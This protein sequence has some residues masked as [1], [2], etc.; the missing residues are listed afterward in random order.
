MSHY[1]FIVNPTSGRGNGRRRLPQ[2]EQCLNE[3][4]V[5]YELVLTERPLHATEIAYRAAQD[6][7]DVVVAVGGDGT[8]NETINGLMRAKNDGH[9]Q[10][11]MAVLP[12]GRGNDFAFG[13]GMSADLATDCAIIANGNRRA[14]D[15]GRVTG[16]LHPE[17]RYFG[18]SVGIGFDAVVGFEA[19]KMT[20]LN[21]FVSY[22]VAALK[23]IFLYYQAPLVDIQ[24][25][26]QRVRQPALMVSVMNGPR[27]GGL[28]FM[29]PDA[30]NDDG[31]FDLCIAGAASRGRIFTL[32]PH[33]FNGSQ[34]DQPEIT[35]GQTEQV[36][37]T[38]VDGTLPAHADGETI[39][40]DGQTLTLE[41]LPR[42]LQIICPPPTEG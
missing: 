15:I 37:V 18:N 11:A 24:S 29:S 23:T 31:L 35:F 1:T 28:F 33:F 26:G 8:V 41:L 30:K 27:Q 19:L 38:A 25:N 14:I 4:G 21:G 2:I 39:S 12:V 3:K 40:A 17:G 5:A 10:T 36:T 16:G 13:M 9:N 22:V 6:G 42:Q 32:L 7:C 20:R 34:F